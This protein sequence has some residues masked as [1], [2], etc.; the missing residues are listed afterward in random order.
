M[1]EQQGKALAT[2]E[3]EG[4]CIAAEIKTKGTNNNICK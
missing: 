3:S 1:P 4:I 2:L